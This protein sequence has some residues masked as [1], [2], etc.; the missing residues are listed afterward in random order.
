MF[1]PKVSLSKLTV[2][3]L[4]LGSLVCVYFL[5]YQ[6]SSP[7]SLPNIDFI[8]IEKTKRKLSVYHQGQLIK[9]YKVSLGFSPR[10]HKE[11]EGDGKT[12]E[13]MYTISAK[14]P[15]SQFHLALK[16]SYPNKVDIMN[17]QKQGYSPGGNILIH[18]VS[19]HFSW[20]G[21]LHVIKDWTLG[22]VA[23]TNN[24]IEEI[25]AATPIGSRVEIKP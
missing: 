7:Q 11:R 1:L 2:F 24:E 17:A 18:G 3:L 5:W 14:N 10:G 19:K 9:T 20:L 4:F 15:K 21:K 16:I 6:S 25:Y 23:V 13:G 8:L 22:C 12:P